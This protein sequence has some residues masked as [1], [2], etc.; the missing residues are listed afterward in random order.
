[1]DK[2][3]KDNFYDESYDEVEDYKVLPIAKEKKSLCGGVECDF[4]PFTKHHKKFKEILGDVRINPTR[5]EE[6]SLHKTIIHF[7]K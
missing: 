1:M 2:E 6:V 5:V 7:N 3:I 4:V